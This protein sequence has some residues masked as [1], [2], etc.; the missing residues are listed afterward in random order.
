M[1]VMRIKQK[2]G[3]K[4][5]TQN[6]PQ[7]PLVCLETLTG[8][9]ANGVRWNLY[10]PEHSLPTSHQSP[11]FVIYHT[12][13]LTLWSPVIDTGDQQPQSHSQCPLLLLES[14]ILLA[15]YITGSASMDSTSLR[16]KI[17][18]T[19]KISRKF[20]KAKLELAMC[21]QLFTLHLHC[22]YSD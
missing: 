14:K 21:W 12:N 7:Q 19:I 3:E 2:F 5:K 17:F 15:L 20:Q 22:I 11:S 10:A 4:N 9:K 16:L 13:N 8:S 18:K 1:A 6:K